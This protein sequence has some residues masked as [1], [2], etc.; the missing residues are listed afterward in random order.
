MTRKELVEEFCKALNQAN[1]GPFETT[2]YSEA[3]FID[4]VNDDEIKVFI[5]E[6]KKLG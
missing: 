3:V 1:L 4:K 5:R 6:L 2:I